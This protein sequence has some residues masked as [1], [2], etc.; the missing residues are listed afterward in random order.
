MI[1]ISQLKD[2]LDLG[3]VFILALIFIYQFGNKFDQLNEKMNRIIALIVLMAGQNG[4]K[5]KIEDILTDK[6]LKVVKSLK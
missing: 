1:N 6:E 5:K 4:L 2:F 3:G